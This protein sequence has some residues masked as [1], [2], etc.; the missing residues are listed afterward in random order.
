VASSRVTRALSA[1]GGAAILAVLVWQLGSAPFVHGLRAVDARALVAA[2]CTG[3]V[4]TVACAWRWQLVARRLGVAL[5]LPAAVAAYYRSQLLNTVLPGGVLG[6]VERGV[7]HGRSTGDVGLGLRAVAWERLAG[8]AV[9]SV[10]LVLALVLF[11]SPVRPFLAVPVTVV[12]VLAVVV[13]LLQRGGGPGDRALWPRAL[14]TARSDVRRA[15]LH[16]SAWPGIVLSSTLVVAAHTT[17]FLIAAT[18]VGTRAPLGSLLPLA[19]LNLVAMSVPVSLAGWGPREGAAAWSFAVSG[20]GAAQ[21][22]AAGTTYGVLAAVAVLPGL[23]VVLVAW[24]H[25]RSAV[26][27]VPRQRPAPSRRGGA[28]V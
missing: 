27:R 9:Q 24:C 18:A 15:L 22:V 8:Q 5:A 1:A 10:V 23:A 21:G 17:T 2:M 13:V 20:H 28:R 4:A 25:R 14:R 16:R 26:A 19:L 7:Q 3:L 12:A 11:P 6:D